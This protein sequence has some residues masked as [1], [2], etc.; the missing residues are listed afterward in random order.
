MLVGATARSLKGAADDESAAGVNAVSPVACVVTYNSVDLGSDIG[1][2]RYRD[3]P[4]SVDAADLVLIIITAAALCCNGTAPDGDVPRSGNAGARGEAASIKMS[5]ASGF[6]A[7][8]AVD[9]QAAINFNGG[10]GTSRGD[11]VVSIQL[12]CQ[13]SCTAD[14]V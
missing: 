13:I 11:R 5:T 6:K 12:D 2:R 9:G 3:I 8:T 7:A 10:A 1:P 4:S 14:I